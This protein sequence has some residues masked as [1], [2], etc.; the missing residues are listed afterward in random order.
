MNNDD[1]PR[2]YLLAGTTFLTVIALA[3]V[4]LLVGFTQG[5]EK[6]AIALIC[7]IAILIFNSVL[8]ASAGNWPSLL[9]M[10]RALLWLGYAWVAIACFLGSLGLAGI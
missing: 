3:G 7:S 6:A 8:L 1:K 4:Y 10:G 5:Q 9:R 2:A